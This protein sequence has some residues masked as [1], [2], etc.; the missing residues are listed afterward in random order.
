M[1]VISLGKANQALKK[2][3]DLDENVVA[4]L[5]ESRFP[6]VDARLDWLEGQAAKAKAVNSKQVDLTQGTFT[7]TEL[8]NGK[9]QLKLLG[10]IAGGYTADVTPTMTGNNSPAPYAVAASSFFG[11]NNAP[12]K[13]FDKNASTMWQ[14]NVSPTGWISL[15]FGPGNTKKIIQ[16]TITAPTTQAPKNWTFEGSNDNINWTVL[17]ARSNQTGWGSNEKRVFN[18]FI[19]NNSFRYY[20]LNVTANNGA[21]TL[22]V[23]ELEMMES[24]IQNQ[25][26]PSGTWESPIIDCGDNW[27]DT[28]A[29]D[30]IKNTVA[31]GT[32]V[33]L[34]I[35]S[36]T[37]GVTFT[38]YVTFD[39]AHLPQARYVKIRAT[40]TGQ[41]GS[42]G[43]NTNLDFNQSDP[44]NTFT[45]DDK[46]IADGSLRFKT[47]Y[48]NAMNNE[49]AV[50]TGTMLSAVI[51]KTQ[52][53]TIEGITV[54]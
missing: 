27:L 16:Y 53:K 10:T 49:G 41:S 6:T 54:N 19:N 48:T 23:Y 37:D 45:L 24:S 17:D 20:R 22:S 51:D 40:L 14:A 44:Q 50:G 52:F 3:K 34:E 12:W 5:A 4:P 36:S 28:T 35:C 11:T 13:A 46:L 42:G 9:V 15:D 26:A 18:S 25:Y 2:I 31:T 39:P 8:V 7:N 30:I 32:N 21:T 29:I 33:T 38:P 43:T 47:S 1:D